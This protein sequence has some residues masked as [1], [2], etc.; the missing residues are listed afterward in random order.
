MISIRKMNADDVNQVQDVGQIAWSD[1]ATKE[2]GRKIVYP[3]RA[4]PLIAAYLKS[5][6]DGCLVAD[7]GGKIVGSAFCH[8]WG[9]TGWVGPLEVLPEYQ[10][11]KVGRALLS[12]CW[13]YLSACQVCG[14]ETSPKSEKNMHFYSSSGYAAGASILVADKLV[15]S[16][17]QYRAEEIKSPTDFDSSELCNKVYPGLDLSKEIEAALAGLGY[18]YATEHGF[19]ILHTFSRGDHAHYASVKALIIDPECKKPSQELFNLL[20]TCESKSQALGKDSLMLRFSLEH[21]ELASILP[22]LGYTYK[23]V[24]IRMTCKGQFSEHG[25]YQILSWAG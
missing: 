6:P 21:R 18:V 25:E 11:K 12:A 4:E 7:D 2:A 5:D 8:R 13:S 19:A 15:A 3:K 22:S 14:L 10:N 9:T 23:A 20:S 1:M 16:D 24:N 17:N